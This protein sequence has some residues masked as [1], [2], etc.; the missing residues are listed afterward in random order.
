MY[1][2]SRSSERTPNSALSQKDGAKVKPFALQARLLGLKAEL[3]SV[4]F[5]KLA[6]ELEAESFVNRAPRI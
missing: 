5:N 1:R 3:G 2:P 4:S 6:D